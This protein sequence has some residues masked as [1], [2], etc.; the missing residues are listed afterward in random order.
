MLW[1]KVFHII[2]VIS[3][4]AGLFYL[5]RI[6]VNLSMVDLESNLRVSNYE[7]LEYKR[8]I[9]MAKKLYRFMG[10]LM[11]LSIF[12]G[13]WLWLGYGIGLGAE[14]IWMHLKLICVTLLLI[15]HLYCGFLLRQFI[16]IES[17]KSHIWFR[18]FNEFP[19]LILFITIILV[20][21][22]PF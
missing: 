11:L 20:V 9:L 19:V 16:A 2:F 15:Y 5:P 8:L 22:K 21:I 1:I 4:F 13:V 18:W 10:P 14:N 7:N 6:F 17:K 3:W 12:F